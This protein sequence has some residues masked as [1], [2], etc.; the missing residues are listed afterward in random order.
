[1]FSQTTEYALRAIAFLATDPANPMTSQ[2]IADKTRVPIGYLAKVLQALGRAGLVVSQRGLHGGFVLAHAPEDLTMLRVVNAMEPLE[3]TF[4]CPL[5]IT[6]HV[7]LCPLHRR[8]N[9]AI[10]AVEEIL[11]A[12]TFDDML[13]E[14]PD[15]MPLCEVKVPAKVTGQRGR[16]SRGR[17]RKSGPAVK[18]KSKSKAKSKARK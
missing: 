17:P 10:A 3:R 2:Q 15:A 9:A 6:G 16:K 5:G 7:N 18:P 14:S 13:Q 4:E 11:T 1:L 8:L 12:T